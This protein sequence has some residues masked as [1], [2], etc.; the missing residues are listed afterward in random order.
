MS[1]LLCK[2]EACHRLGVSRATIDRWRS[3]LGKPQPVRQGGRVYYRESEVNAYIEG[4]P[5]LSSSSKLLQ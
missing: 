4:L 5:H 3:K 2:K 1:R